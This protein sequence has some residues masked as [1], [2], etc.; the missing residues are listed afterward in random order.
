MSTPHDIA[1]ILAQAAVAVRLRKASDALE[2]VTLSS[3]E[4]STLTDMLRVLAAGAKE[5]ES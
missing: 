4:V 3:E 2:G 1:R 5:A